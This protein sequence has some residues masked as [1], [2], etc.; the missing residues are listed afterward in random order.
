MWEA[1]FFWLIKCLNILMQTR[2][3]IEC[4]AVFCFITTVV[5]ANLV[6][7]KLVDLYP[8]IAGWLLALKCCFSIVI[9]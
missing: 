3:V 7:A 5:C 6:P 1:G 8:F 2:Y 9:S 4:F